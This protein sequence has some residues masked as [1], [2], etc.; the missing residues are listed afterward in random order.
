MSTR[1][2]GPVLLVDDNPDVRESI[3]FVLASEG[4]DVV[5]A[6][7]GVDALDLLRQG[8]HPSV[9][10]LDLHMPRMDGWGFRAEQQRDPALADIPVV[11]YSGHHDLEVAAQAMGIECYFPKPFDFD[12]LI[13]AIKRYNP[14]EV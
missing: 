4:I 11:L 2:K 10:L 12:L 14:A 3:R 9:V 1:A 13:D 6:C 5:M 8:W 7:D